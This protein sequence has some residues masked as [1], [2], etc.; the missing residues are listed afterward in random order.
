MHDTLKRCKIS[1]FLPKFN[2]VTQQLALLHRE[3]ILVENVLMHKEYKQRQQVVKDLQDVYIHFNQ[4]KAWYDQ[5]YVQQGLQL[6]D[7]QLEYL[8]ALNLKQF[9]ADT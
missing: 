5:Y 2:Q 4:A 9:D 7:K 3:N 8:H 6:L 1:W